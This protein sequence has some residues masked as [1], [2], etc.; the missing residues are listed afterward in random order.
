MESIFVRLISKKAAAILMKVR[1]IR[2]KNEGKLKNRPFIERFFVV[3]D[4]GSLIPNQ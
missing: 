2:R 4:E 3:K 1:E